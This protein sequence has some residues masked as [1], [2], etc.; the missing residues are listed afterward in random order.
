M[1]GS[2]VSSF[3]DILPFKHQSLPFPSFEITHIDV[4]EPRMLTIGVMALPQ[5][6]VAS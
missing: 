3:P 5:N 1:D 2:F 6:G 4:G